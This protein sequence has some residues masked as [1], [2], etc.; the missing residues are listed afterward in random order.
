MTTR[1][2]LPTTIPEL[3]QQPEPQ[4]A[5]I[6]GHGRMFFPDN[7]SITIIAGYRG[8][9]T[10][11]SSFLNTNLFGFGWGNITAYL[12]DGNNVVRTGAGNDTIFGGAGMNNIST[13][14]GN[15][16]LYGGDGTNYLFGGAG[17]DLLVGGSGFNV[18]NGGTGNDMLIG[19]EG[20]SILNGGTG[21]DTIMFGQGDQVNG[22]RGADKFFVMLK[23]NMPNAG[24]GFINDF[25]LQEGDSLDLT[26][27]PFHTLGDM[28]IV[29][30][31]L[32]VY[33]PEGTVRVEGV[34]EQ[35]TLMGGIYAAHQL[36]FL[37][38]DMDFGGRG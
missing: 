5:S 38:A 24:Q 31:T 4:S 25:S 21:D 28:K 35:I 27:I 14:A 37:V 1:T 32:M 26:G 8:D 12:G 30:N 34:G 15:D 6:S 13:G 36:G 9:A 33:N 29:G 2:Q 17:D 11:Q 18:L 10:V 19:G 16:A 20:H 22:G 7:N 23:A 3:F